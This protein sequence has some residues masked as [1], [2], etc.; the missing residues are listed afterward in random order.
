M[1]CPFNRSAV[2]NGLLASGKSVAD[3]EKVADETALTACLEDRCRWWGDEI[4]PWCCFQ[5]IP[6]AIESASY[7]G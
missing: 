2:I 3:A 7:G 6:A 4:H 5:L 1:S